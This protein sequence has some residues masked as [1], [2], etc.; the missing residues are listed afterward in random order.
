MTLQQRI[1]TLIDKKTKLEWDHTTLLKSFEYTSSQLDSLRSE[2]FLQEKSLLALKDV[3][4]ILSATS[5]DQCIKLANAALAAIFETN[6]T[7]KYSSEDSSFQID[8]GVF[9]TD[10][11]EGNGGGYLAVISLVFNVFLLK[12]M[13]SR[14]F[15]VFDEQFTCVSE[16]YFQNFF[17]FIRRLTQDLGMDILLVTHDVRVEDD[18]VDHIYLMEDGEAKKIK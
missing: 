11:K 12:K 9:D 15:M 2:E 8:T 3:K 4:P 10:L 17:Q 5:I 7:L 1:Q 13:G 6:A 14:L 16:Q 18:M